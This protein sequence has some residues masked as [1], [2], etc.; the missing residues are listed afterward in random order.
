MQFGLYFTKG[1]VLLVD[2]AT[3][4][5]LTT[6]KDGVNRW[7]RHYENNYTLTIYLNLYES[8]WIYIV[9]KE[10]CKVCLTCIECYDIFK[11]NK[12]KVR[13]TNE[14]ENRRFP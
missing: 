13:F 12:C 3:G 2:K 1:T 9:K 10:K 4:E 14:E 11:I 6:G 7:L 8:N 5:I